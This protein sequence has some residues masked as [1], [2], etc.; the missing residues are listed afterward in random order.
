MD[1]VDRRK[2]RAATDGERR[3]V[4]RR[5]FPRWR[6][7]F[8]VRF[9]LSDEKESHTASPYEVGEAGIS[10]RCPVAM[11]LESTLKLE[12][13]LSEQEEWIKVKGVVRH[14][15]GALKG[16]EFLNLSRNDRLKI[17]DFVTA[18]SD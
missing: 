7:G 5:A 4:N 9:W 12:F 13:R 2:N 11:E 1:I 14:V 15:E 17:I 3:Q 16:I 8:E 10:F 18:M 6:T